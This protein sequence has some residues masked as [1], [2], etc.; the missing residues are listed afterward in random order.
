VL[1]HVVTERA[2]GATLAQIA[3]TLNCASIP[4]PGQGRR[5]Y[6]SYVH[7]LLRTQDAA[8]LMQKFDPT[9]L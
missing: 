3:E 1:E 6:A 4:T 2:R 7:R 9:L 8:R 5:W